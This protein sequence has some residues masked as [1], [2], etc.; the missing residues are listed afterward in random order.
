MLNFRVASNPL[1]L[2]LIRGQPKPEVCD[3][4][5][6]TVQVMAGSL[7]LVPVSFG[8]IF[9]Y[10]AAPLLT[11]IGLSSALIIPILVT[12][13]A[14]RM[15]SRSLRDHS[16]DLLRLTNLS[17]GT[18]LWA[19]VMATLYRWRSLRYIGVGLMPA[20]I[21]SIGLT[22]LVYQVGIDR[23]HWC[24]TSPLGNQ[25]CDTSRVDQ[26]RTDET[27]VTRIM[28]VVASGIVA[29]IGSSGIY[30][31][32]AAVG[33]GIARWMRSTPFGAMLAVILFSSAVIMWPLSFT[34]LSYKV[35]LSSPSDSL[36]AALFLAI[37][38]CLLAL[39]TAKLC[40]QRIRRPT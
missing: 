7:I 18:I 27:T 10:A 32:A 33:V 34:E 16:D 28:Q 6:S 2:Y 39:L 38:P 5:I 15:I 14:W 25:Y 24:I 31:F 37:T 3:L 19:Y 1:F 20:I 13:Y 23:I 35:F 21:V 22:V 12:T 29:T 40:E 17:S 30:L 9:V 26:T 8:L 36:R 11:L 4:I